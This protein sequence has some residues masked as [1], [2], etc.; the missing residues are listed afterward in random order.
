MTNQNLQN[1]LDKRMSQPTV[2]LCFKVLLDNVI[3][4]GLK[5]RMTKAEIN[6]AF[7]KEHKKF[8][9][10]TFRSDYLLRQSGENP[11]NAIG[12]ESDGNKFFIRPSFLNG[13]TPNDLKLTIEKINRQFLEVTA[14]QKVLYDEISK[15]GNLSIEKRKEFIIYMLLN[16]ETDRKGQ[17]FEVT[18]Y[19]ILKSFY[20]IRGF[21]LNRFST[22]YSNDGGIDYTSQTS[23][24]QVTTKLSDKKFDDDIDKA[25]LKNRIF[26]FR[27]AVT[28][29]DFS[30]MDNELVSD[31]ISA[32]DLLN[33]LEYLFLKKPEVNSS[34]ILNTILTEFQREYYL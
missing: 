22:I 23:I 14:K 26:V 17:S 28:N 2:I 3:K 15:A 29:F 19:A 31:Y 8:G 11:D 24:Y 9:V 21:E 25:P 4:N 6:K 5:A 27:E 20:S 33:H 13:L 12:V 1:Y 32:D 34:M 18:A 7:D 10:Q 30:K 16:K